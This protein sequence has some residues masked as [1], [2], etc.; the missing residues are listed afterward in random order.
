LQLHAPADDLRNRKARA[1][2]IEEWGEKRMEFDP[3]RF[4]H[5]AAKSVRFGELRALELTFRKHVF[6]VVHS[7]PR[8]GPIIL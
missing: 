1:Q 6:P 5:D 7:L 4:G 8:R 3:N 2:L